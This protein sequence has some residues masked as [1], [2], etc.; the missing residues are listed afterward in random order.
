MVFEFQEDEN[1]EVD[2]DSPGGKFG[3]RIGHTDGEYA[4]PDRVLNMV[5]DRNVRVLTIGRGNTPFLLVI[6]LYPWRPFRRA[7]ILIEQGCV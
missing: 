3:Y 2:P 7:S 1:S 5:Y 4:I 6:G